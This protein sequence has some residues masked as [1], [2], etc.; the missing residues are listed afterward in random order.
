MRER[1]PRIGVFL[2][3]VTDEPQ[4]TRAWDTGAAGEQ[5]VGA[6]LDSLVG[7]GLAVLHDR[8]IPRTRANIDHL[9]VC[10]QGV[11]V[12]DA[13]KYK[14]RPAL[15]VEGGLFRPRTETLV[16]GGRTCTGLV[17]G[18]LKQVDLVRAALDDPHVPVVG[19]LCFVDAEWPLF[20]GAFQTRGVHVLWPRRLG[21]LVAGTGTS[22]GDTTAVDVPSV[23][24]RLA[25]AFPPA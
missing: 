5:V 19:V 1:F 11:F 7:D 21:Q 15:R 17:D 4:S 10:H 16:V 23:H 12:V 22:T 9:V 18:V 3:A 8:R 14:G 24:A 13:K 2:L 20:G 6:R 25:K